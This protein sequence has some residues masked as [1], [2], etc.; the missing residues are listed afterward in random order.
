MITIIRLID[1][2]KIGIHSQHASLHMESSEKQLGQIYVDA[3]AHVLL[4]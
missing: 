3:M 4:G 2:K 1:I